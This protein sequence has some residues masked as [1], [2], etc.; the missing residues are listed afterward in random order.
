MDG[1]E[2]SSD[3]AVRRSKR[4]DYYDKLEGPQA[5]VPEAVLSRLAVWL[6]GAASHALVTSY[7]ASASLPLTLRR[8]A[9]TETAATDAAALPP[10]LPGL[11]QSDQGDGVD[12]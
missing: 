7:D 5:S 8:G 12:V 9:M 11:D 2:G 1:S 10:L 3:S 6:L 4:V